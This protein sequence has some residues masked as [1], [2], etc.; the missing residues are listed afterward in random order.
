VAK[1]L[2]RESEYPMI[3]YEDALKK[4]EDFSLLE[5]LRPTQTKMKFSVIDHQ[6]AIRALNNVLANDL[7]NFRP[8]PAFRVSTV[9]GYVVRRPKRMTKTFELSGRVQATLLDSLEM[10]DE[11]SQSQ[12]HDSLAFCYQVNTGGRLPDD[13]DFIVVPTEKAIRSSA[14]NRVDLLELKK[15]SYVRERGSDMGMDFVLKSGTIIGPPE[16][17]IILSMGY[18]EFEVFR[19]P[20]IGILST[21]DE[22]LS[23]SEADFVRKFRSQPELVVDVNCPLLSTLL[24]IHKY[25]V[26]SLGT[27]RDDPDEIENKLRSAIVSDRAD[28]IIVTGGASMGT[29]DWVKD[30]IRER[31]EDSEIHFGR[32]NMKPGKPVAFAS[33]PNK[34]T[35]RIMPLFSLPGNPVSAYVTTQVL[36]LPYL[37]LNFRKNFKYKEPLDLTLVGDVMRV[38]VDEIC[39]K[40]MAYKFD[41]RLEFARAKTLAGPNADGI[42]PVRVSYAQQ[43]SRLL[44][45][46]DVDCLLLVSSD[47]KGTQFAI[48]DIFIACKLKRHI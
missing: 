10:V 47:R 40:H 7:T 3:S 43:S 36:V 28:V 22:L 26:V 16:L 2:A 41:G 6:S 15:G 1:K 23:V 44:S 20:R 35:G 46:K 48:G 33:I 32:V 8:M 24:S 14:G 17:S 9:D 19:R 42:V 18:K 34:S 29:R 27:A 37:E 21:G 5:P 4:M 31:F 13:E 12:A 25:P 38:I 11:F 39:D 30:V 45:L